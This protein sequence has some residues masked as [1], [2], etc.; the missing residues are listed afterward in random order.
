[1]KGQL[2][3]VMIRLLFVC[4]LLTTVL[5]FMLD[6][7]NTKPRWRHPKIKSVPRSIDSCKTCG[8]NIKAALK[9][10]SQ[11]WEKQEGNY[12]NFSLQLSNKCHGSEKAIITKVNTQ[13]GSQIVYD[14][15]R[16]RILT[17]NQEMLDNF[18][19]ENPL[20]NKKWQTCA[21]VGNGGILANSS[22]GKRIDSAQF[23]I[24]CN[25][26][27]VTDGYEKDVGVKT[28][29]VTANPT[30][31]LQKY[32]ALTG[33]RLPLMKKLQNYGDSLL[34]LPP[35]SFGMNTAVC[36]R[37]LYTIED[38]GG[39]VRP[40]FINPDYLY[41]VSLFWRSQGL[42][43][44]R[45]STG[46]IMVSLALELCETVHLYGFWPFEVHPYS[47]QELAN[48]YYDNKKATSFHAMPVEFKLLLELHKK[49]VLKM[50][51]GDCEPNK[52]WSD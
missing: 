6:T 13:L 30:I 24:R 21:V 47:F 26:P 45:P 10:Y 15:E 4:I 46:I 50:N 42:K 5:W 27:P 32:G 16:K 8:E 9:I 29:I 41:N 36:L 25:L 44:T 38:F 33:R 11:A 12:Q 18:P 3:S 7:N 14:G 48:H 1:M 37:V 39:P 23:V 34:L 17:V 35:F 2:L 28:N 40:V 20:P 22:C 49:G 31:F 51:L 52:D 43:A 19:N